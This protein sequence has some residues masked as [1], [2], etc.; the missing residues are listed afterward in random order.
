MRLSAVALLGAL[1]L[2]ACDATALDVAPPE[3]A[4]A[5]RADFTCEATATALPDGSVL[6]EGTLTVQTT[7]GGNPEGVR[8]VERWV[9]T[10]PPAAEI[11]TTASGNL[12]GVRCQGTGAVRRGAAGVEVRIRS[13]ELTI[14][15]KTLALDR[16]TFAEAPLGGF[17]CSGTATP[18][19]DGSALFEGTLSVQTTAGGNPDGVRTVERWVLS[20][21]PAAEVQTTASGN[22]EGVACEGSGSSARERGRLVVAI[23]SGVLRV[24]EAEIPLAGGTFTEVRGRRR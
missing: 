1:A 11:Q 12:Q 20:G 15:G 16:G 18:R 8:T 13:G 9:L 23:A 4:D 21:P 19:P 24:G 22:P 10:G 5:R 17:S 14:G 7:A 3:F 2:T 6:F